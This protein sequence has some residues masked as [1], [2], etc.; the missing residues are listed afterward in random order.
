[1]FKLVKDQNLIKIAQELDE[2]F[3]SIAIV[4]GF[5]EDVFHNKEEILLSYELNHDVHEIDIEFIKQMLTI[6]VWF[7]N[8]VRTG[9]TIDLKDKID[10]FA[11]YGKRMIYVENKETNSVILRSLKNI[12]VLSIELKKHKEEK[13]GKVIWRSI[14]EISIP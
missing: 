7:K 14:L 1:M 6:T 13:N 10:I 12:R 3:S 5:Y 8:M 9:L 11:I 2:F 4:R